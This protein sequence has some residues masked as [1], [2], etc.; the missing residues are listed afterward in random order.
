MTAHR[1][2]DPTTITAGTLRADSVQAMGT[3][4][5]GTTVASGATLELMLTADASML[6]SK[7]FKDQGYIR[8]TRDRDD[9]SYARLPTTPETTMTKPMPPTTP[10]TVPRSASRRVVRA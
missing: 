3:T 4:A 9:P 1:S 5:G 10:A 2:G 6:Q 8:G 7:F